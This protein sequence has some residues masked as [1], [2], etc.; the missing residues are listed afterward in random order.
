ME[1][2]VVAYKYHKKTGKCE[3]EA[4]G[5]ARTSTTKRQVSARSRLRVW[6]TNTTK[7][8]VSAR[9]RLR[10]WRS[11]PCL[12]EVAQAPALTDAGHSLTQK[13]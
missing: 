4:Q 6:R 7:R 5:V 9:S 8:Q 13:T 11:C 12:P 3:I 1:A 10:V 2:Q